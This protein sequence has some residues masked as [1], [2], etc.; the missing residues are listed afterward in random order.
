MY[1][2]S[3]ITLVGYDG[4]GGG[5]SAFLM[6]YMGLKLISE[7]INTRFVNLNPIL[8]ATFNDDQHE[9]I[10]NIS[11][12]NTITLED[13][14]K[15]M[16]TS[17]LTPDRLNNYLNQKDI[18]YIIHGRHHMPPINIHSFLN[19]NTNVISL[20]NYTKKLFAGMI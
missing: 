20:I 3:K 4:D 11:P 14:M 8:R 16:N 5:L 12:S 18:K 19:S 1:D 7:T 2:N 6:S 15:E 10:F 17:E 13:A 9:K